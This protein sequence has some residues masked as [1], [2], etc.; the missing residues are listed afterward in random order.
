MNSWYH[1]TPRPLCYFFCSSVPWVV[2]DATRISIQI[3]KSVLADSVE[4]LLPAF[5][6][7]KSADLIQDLLYSIMLVDCQQKYNRTCCS[8]LVVEIEQF[9]KFNHLY[10]FNTS[11]CFFFFFFIII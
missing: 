11:A 9:L 8:R 7:E 3:A 5:M 4:N 2:Y 1:M 6:Y 10:I